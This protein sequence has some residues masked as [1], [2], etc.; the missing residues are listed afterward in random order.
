ML[1]CYF[2]KME[3]WQVS[4]SLLGPEQGLPPR[5]GAGLSHRLLRCLFMV[6]PQPLHGPQQLQDPST[7]SVETSKIQNWSS[8][9]STQSF[10]E[11]P[12]ALDT[13][14]GASMSSA[15]TTTG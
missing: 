13:H 1:A 12:T 9:T 7:C 14:E 2:W 10:Y 15:G 11:R 8:S 4:C 5:R 3:T 6:D